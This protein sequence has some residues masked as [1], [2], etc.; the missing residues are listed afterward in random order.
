VA[1]S[2]GLAALFIPARAQAEQGERD[3]QEA[4][5]ERPE[6]E[7]DVRQVV[8]ERDRIEV[9]RHRRVDVLTEE[10]PAQPRD[11]LEERR[12][13]VAERPLREFHQFEIAQALIARVRPQQIQVG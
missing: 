1:N 11:R 4:E 3:A 8:R 12:R 2:G 9:V 5:L 7:Q 6:Q 13:H 10:Q